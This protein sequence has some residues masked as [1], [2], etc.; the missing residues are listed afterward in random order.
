MHEQI[1]QQNHCVSSMNIEKLN[2]YA[3]SMNL[4]SYADIHYNLYQEAHLF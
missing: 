2:S 1:H 4:D 3:V